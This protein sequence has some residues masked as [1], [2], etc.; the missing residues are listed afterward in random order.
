MLNSNSVNGKSG[1]G[2]SCFCG[3]FIV[4][5]WFVNFRSL[6]VL[7][8]ELMK[9]G[10]FS[11]SCQLDQKMRTPPLKKWT[12]LEAVGSSIDE[13]SSRLFLLIRLPN[14]ELNCKHE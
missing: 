11:V 2:F 6:L 3:T 8:E 7:D 10:L 4:P 14:T 1:N 12:N 9:R 13:A 5:A